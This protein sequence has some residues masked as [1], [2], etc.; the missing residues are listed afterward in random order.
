MHLRLFICYFQYYN[1][2]VVPF[3]SLT[4]K[5]NRDEYVIVMQIK[6]NILIS[7]YL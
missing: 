1:F 5:Y 3:F 4:A 2:I 6:G 7:F